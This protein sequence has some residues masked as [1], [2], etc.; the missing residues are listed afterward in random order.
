MSTA[1]DMVR[2]LAVFLGLTWIGFLIA[3]SAAG[4]VLFTVERVRRFRMSRQLRH[5]LEQ[6]L[7]SPDRQVW[8]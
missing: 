8:S 5:E 2:F 7:S 3:L 4:S 1:A 6:F